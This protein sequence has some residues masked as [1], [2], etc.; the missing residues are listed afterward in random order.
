MSVQITTAFVEQ[1]KSNVFHLAQQKGSKLRDAVRS[2][3]VTGKSHFL[4][5][6]ESTA[7]LKRT[8]R[9]SRYSSS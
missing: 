9:H 2:E 4:K 1:Y 3:T 6:L 8:S 5:E 7:A